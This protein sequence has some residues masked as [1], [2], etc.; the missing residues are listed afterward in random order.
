V[1]EPQAAALADPLCP[2]HD[3]LQYTVEKEPITIDMRQ[4]YDFTPNMR[5][6]KG[7][8]TLPE[9]TSI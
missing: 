5:W 1:Q 9:H 4:G 6:K 2:H 8:S 3:G 7:E